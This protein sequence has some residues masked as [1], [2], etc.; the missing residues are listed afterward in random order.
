MELIRRLVVFSIFMENGEGITG[1][2]PDYI[3]EKWKLVN[4]NLSDEY[5]IAG[6]DMQNQAK[7]RDWQMTWGPIEVK[8]VER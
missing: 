3:M 1:K 2:A 5:I 6:L 7:F 4:M 8:E